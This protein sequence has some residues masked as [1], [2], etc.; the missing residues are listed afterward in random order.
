MLLTSS[1][2]PLTDRVEVLRFPELGS[3]DAGEPKV[4]VAFWLRL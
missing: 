2:R 4:E 3:L 1:S